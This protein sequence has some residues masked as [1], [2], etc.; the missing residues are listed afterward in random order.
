LAAGWAQRLFMPGMLAFAVL[1]FC[2]R[3]GDAMVSSLLGPFLSDQG[4][5][6][7]TIAIMKGTVGSATSLVGAV[8]G[9]WFMFRVGRRFALLFS[10]L[11]QAAV[12]VLYI[13]AAMKIGGVNLLWTVTVLEGIVSTMATVALFTLM[14]DA[15][16]PDHAGTDYTIF[17]SVVV[18]VSSLGGFVA[19]AIADA[20]G[21]VTTFTVGTVLAVVGCVVM[22]RRLDTYPPSQRVAD[23]WRSLSLNAN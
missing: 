6:K 21:F 3:F 22:V 18:L 10:G 19:A 7:E 4:L 8:I 14:M 11:T 16:D 1:I 12:F 23:A 5:T 15:S 9:G 20:F 2:Y 13:L 17:A